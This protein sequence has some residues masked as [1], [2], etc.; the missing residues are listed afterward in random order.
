MQP[1]IYDYYL[2]PNGSIHYWEYRNYE[3]RTF[4]KN[5]PIPPKPMNEYRIHGKN[6]I[7]TKTETQMEK[8][9]NN[10]FY[11]FIKND[12]RAKQAFIDH[13]QER[14]AKAKA[15][16]DKTNLILYHIKNP[17]QPKTI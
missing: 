9:L 3:I 12:E 15:E 8:V 17:N 14:S 5:K 6:G 16:Y 2:L 4:G 10:H 1:T 11:T 7:I 13:Y